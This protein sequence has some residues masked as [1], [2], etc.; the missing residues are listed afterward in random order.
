MPDSKQVI[1]KLTPLADVFAMLNEM[2]KPVAPHDIAVT[3]AMGCVLAVDV[4]AAARPA[5]AIALIDGWA[6]VSADVADAGGYAPVPL[7]KIPPRVETGDD[8]PPG[9]DA[10]LPLD[11]VVVRGA[12]AEAVAAAAGGEGVFAPGGDVDA[13]K[14]LYAAGHRLRATD[15]AALM[16]ADISTVS[17][18]APRVAIV[19]ARED[20]RLV[21][22]AQ[23]IARDCAAQ[24]VVAQSRNGADVADVLAANDADAVVIVGGT[25]TG[26]RDNSVTALAQAGRVACHGIGIAPG[27]TSAVGAAMGK[28]VL[29]VPGR[30]DAALVAWLTIGRHLT[31]RLTGGV[32][33]SPAAR[34]RLT[35]KI[36]STVGLCDVVPVRQEGGNVE[37]L[38]GKVLP[39]SVLA[40]ATG[41][42]VVPADSEG[43]AAGSDVAVHG[44]P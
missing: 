33:A 13:T 44:W 2:A 5:R 4:M 17:V 28:P 7:A 3:D 12:S 18:R 23:V 34:G 24:G 14:P 10:V 42:V 19:T 30:L 16:A 21:P 37:P 39:L 36:T 26:A 6:V 15:L 38:A 35:R 9:A 20:L 27:E 43:Y 1:T 29:I 11:A 41:Y 40:R 8:M 25:G 31:G 32:E 22:A